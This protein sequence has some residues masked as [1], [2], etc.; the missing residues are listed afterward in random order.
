[1][2]VEVPFIFCR[3]VVELGKPAGQR[4]EERRDKYMIKY[5][6]TSVAYR[7]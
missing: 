5:A 3:K 1:M 7:L 6:K 4:T 2:N